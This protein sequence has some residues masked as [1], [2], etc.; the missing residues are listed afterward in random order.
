MNIVDKYRLISQIGY[1]CSIF[2]MMIAIILFFTLKIN[3]VFGFVTG[4]SRKKAI[5]EISEHNSYT[6]ESLSGNIS[7]NTGRKLGRTSKIAGVPITSK[8]PTSKMASGQKET[9][10]T[11]VLSNDETTLLQTDETTLLQTNET[12]VLS[13]NSNMMNGINETTVLNYN[14]NSMQGI[15]ANEF[16]VIKDIVYIHTDI[17]I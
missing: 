5:K 16:M 4:I 6:S 1:I 10:E 9:N 15:A 7:A 17:V 8:I 14:A 13:G 11:A 3:R 2:F 12:T